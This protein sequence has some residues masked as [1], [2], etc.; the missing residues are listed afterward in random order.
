VKNGKF[1]NDT[2]LKQLNKVFETSLINF[3]RR[4]GLHF[5]RFLRSSYYRDP[6]DSFVCFL[7]SHK[8]QNPFGQIINDI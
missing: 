2:Q 3:P 1:N 4:Y 6:F 5:I 8:R 7:V